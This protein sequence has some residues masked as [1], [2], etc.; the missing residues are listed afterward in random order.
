MVN[1]IL[2]FVENKKNPSEAAIAF[3][4]KK[5]CLVH[6][7]AGIKPM[8]G[9]YWECFVVSAS[10]N[11]DNKSAG[12]ADDKADSQVWREQIHPVFCSDSKLRK[13]NWHLRGKWNRKIHCDK[14]FSQR[15]K[16]QF[17]RLDKNRNKL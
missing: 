16:A 11:K 1:F 14:D 8:K 3:N 5:A 6:K 15:L 2:K 12:G 9:E 10:C 4:N 13:S 17:W 7:Q